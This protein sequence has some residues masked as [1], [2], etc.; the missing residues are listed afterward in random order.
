MTVLLAIRSPVTITPSFSIDLTA[1]QGAYGSRPTETSVHG[2]HYVSFAGHN[3]LTSRRGSIIGSCS[4][5]NSRIGVQMI[6]V[7]ESSN[8]EDGR[9]ML[10][11]DAFITVRSP[12]LT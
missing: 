12:A 6:G 10:E 7:Q 9:L 8:S 3:C 4:I 5:E 2:H 11:T 1:F